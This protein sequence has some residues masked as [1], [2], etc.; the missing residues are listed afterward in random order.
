SPARRHLLTPAAVMIS[1]S[2][3]LIIRPPLR[4][5]LFPSTT[6]FR[7]SPAEGTS[8]VKRPSVVIAIS[9][10]ISTSTGDTSLTVPSMWSAGPFRRSEEHTS[11]LQSPDHLVCRP[12]LE[13]NNNKARNS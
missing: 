13:K 2:I 4:P 9:P 5:P 8:A 10:L 12:L 3:L 1:P 11:E 7:S 6:L